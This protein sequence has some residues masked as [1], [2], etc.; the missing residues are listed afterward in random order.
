M[1]QQRE[2]TKPKFGFLKILIKQTNLIHFK[3]VQTNIRIFK[4]NLIAD[5][6]I[7]QNAV[8]MDIYYIWLL[9]SLCQEYFTVRRS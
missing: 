2:S 1:E 8:C 3:F 6:E 9:T 7:N 5:P 4:A